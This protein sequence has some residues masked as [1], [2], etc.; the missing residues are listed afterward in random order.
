M[1]FA[2]TA[3]LIAA[4]LATPLAARAQTL[5][6]PEHQKLARDILSQLIAINTTS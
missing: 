4:S 5:P 6:P 1:T 2:R 3:L